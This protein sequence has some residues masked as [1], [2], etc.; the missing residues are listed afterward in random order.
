MA[1]PLTIVGGIASFAQV[2]GGVVKTTQA[3]Y[4]VCHAVQD[5]PDELRRINETLLALKLALESTQTQVGGFDDDELL[6]PDLRCIMQTNITSIHDDV[7]ALKQKCHDYASPSSITKRERLKWAVLER[8]VVG[9]LLERLKGSESSLTCVLQL[10]NMY[11]PF[12]NYYCRVT[13]TDLTPQSY[14][15]PGDFIAKETGTN[16]TW[17]L[18]TAPSLRPA[19]LIHE[20]TNSNGNRKHRL[21]VTEMWTIRLPVSCLWD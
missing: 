9:N 1:D 19:Q 15:S 8:R 16:R 5:A 14:V 6:P 10:I 21:M 12:S 7:I 18:A 3:I 2:L 11:V 4:N 20:G 13:N 17:N